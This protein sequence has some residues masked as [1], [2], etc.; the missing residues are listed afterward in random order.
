MW[1]VC[2]AKVT[3]ILQPAGT[4]HGH[5]PGSRSVGQSQCPLP[6]PLTCSV[7]TENGWCRA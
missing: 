7:P 6:L 3:A 1:V 2:I 5:F 4:I